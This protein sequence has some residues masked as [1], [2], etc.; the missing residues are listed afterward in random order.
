[1]KKWSA[2]KCYTVYGVIFGICFPLSAFV[3]LYFT[4]SNNSLAALIYAAHTDP[5]LYLIYT[6]PLVLGIIARIAGI[7][8]DKIHHLAEGLED[9]VKVKTAS[10]VQA[11]EEAKQANEL[12]GH[13]ANH[14]ALTGLFNRRHFQATLDGWVGFATRYQ[15]QGSLVFIDL[16]KFKY[17]RHLR[18]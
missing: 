10:L 2:A 9:L 13:I 5:L 14:D 18:S 1:M 6:A 12:V 16:D 3:L 15:R 17:V 8:Q 11:L 4:P 7:R